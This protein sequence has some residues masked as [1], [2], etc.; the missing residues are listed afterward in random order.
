MSTHNYDL[1]VIGGGPAGQKG[2]L[3]AAKLGA[4]EVWATDISPEAVDATREN[5]SLEDAR[6]FLRPATGH[7]RE[8][9]EPGVYRW[10]E[11]TEGK[12][13]QIEL[14]SLAPKQMTL[15]WLKVLRAN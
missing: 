9:T 15:H 12:S 2:A 5:A 8:E 3:A 11:S 13:A 1:V 6:D 10:R 4:R 7:Y 14:E